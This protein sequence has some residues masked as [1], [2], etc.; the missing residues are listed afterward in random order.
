[1]LALSDIEVT[2]YRYCVY[3]IKDKVKIVYREQDYNQEDFFFLN[4][5]TKSKHNNFKIQV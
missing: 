4:Q 5:E 1:M 3:I 2:Y